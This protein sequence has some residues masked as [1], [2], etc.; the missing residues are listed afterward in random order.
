MSRS[1]QSAESLLLLPGEIL[2]L[3]SSFCD[4]RSLSTIFIAAQG[5]STAV[6]SQS[7]IRDTLCYRY[8]LLSK[9]FMVNPDI[10][11]VL[12]AIRQE[13]DAWEDTCDYSSWCAVIDYFEKQQQS[14][15]FII[16]CGPLE[17]QYGVIQAYLTSSKW[18]ATAMQY[19]YSEWELYQYT[20]GIPMR[21]PPLRHRYGNLWGDKEIL[22]RLR[23][24]LNPEYD[25]RGRYILVPRHLDFEANPSICFSKNEESPSLVC[26]WD[27]QDDT[28]WELGVERLGENV[29]RIMNRYGRSFPVKEETFD[30]VESDEDD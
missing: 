12:D 26:Y 23:F 13:I 3:I 27:E 11:D 19:W 28:D 9:R 21:S 5:S 24:S 10:S 6:D 20:L 15:E 1:L 14:S 18:T 8:K 4:G 22:S 7:L 2:S 29:I 30:D 16:W 25:G 17:T